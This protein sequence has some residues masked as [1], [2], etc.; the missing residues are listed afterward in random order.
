VATALLW[1]L[2]GSS[3]LGGCATTPSSIDEGGDGQRVGVLS[4]LGDRLQVV[5]AGVGE[6]GRPNTW[7]DIG[8]WRTDQHVEQYARQV[9]RSG[10]RSEVVDINIDR[11]VS[12]R[13]YAGCGD[14]C[15]TRAPTVRVEVLR[16]SLSRW[17]RDNGLDYLVLFVRSDNSRALLGPLA[18]SKA[19]VGLGLIPGS[20]AVARSATV[21]AFV[22]AIVIEAE[23]GQV[24]TSTG[25]F[26]NGF[27]DA[28]VPTP[29]A[30]RWPE[31]GEAVFSRAIRQQLE[32]GVDVAL[33][34]LGLL[35]PVAASG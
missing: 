33:E 25:F 30:G 17:R 3:I 16:T 11:E 32:D 27:V 20:V 26:N 8:A 1:L 19:G 5:N 7:V 35:G 34:Q 23:T 24:L 6:A 29:A 21:F 28:G 14:S 15:D 4:L 22:E 18:T 31:G 9:I 13:I 2:I 10:G 12:K